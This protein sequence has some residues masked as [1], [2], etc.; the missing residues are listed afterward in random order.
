MASSEGKQDRPVRAW[1]ASRA[2]EPRARG[3]SL[4]G[5]GGFEPPK[6]RTTRF[7]VWPIWP[8]W[9]L[10][11]LICPRRPVP[12][13]GLTSRG[14]PEGHPSS[15][16]A[17]P[18][19]GGQARDVR[20]VRRRVHPAG[21]TPP[22]GLG[23]RWRARATPGAPAPVSSVR[24]SCFHG[25]ARLAPGD[26]ASRASVAPAD[27]AVIVVRLRRGSVVSGS[28]ASVGP[29]WGRRWESNPQPPDY[30]SGALPIEPRRRL[31]TWAWPAAERRLQTR[32]PPERSGERDRIGRDAPP[33]SPHAGNPPATARGARVRA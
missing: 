25:A 12:C 8:L 14:I 16:Q 10:P 2:R 26:P 1:G 6:V 23:P 13:P 22:R 3:R 9:N 32:L 27:P 30:K 11:A 4:V 18:A 5:R 7:T 20:F 33:S 28:P 19:R 29:G 17:T 15:E 31:S 21:P 24:L